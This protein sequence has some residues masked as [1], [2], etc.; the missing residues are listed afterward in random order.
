LSNRS[1]VLVNADEH[2]NSGWELTCK[3]QADFDFE[4]YAWSGEGIL[5]HLQRFLD[6]FDPDVISIT[7]YRLGP[8]VQPHESE[9]NE[10]DCWHEEHEDRQGIMLKWALKDGTGYKFV[11]PQRLFDEISALI[12]SGVTKLRS[13]KYHG[14]DPDGKM[15]KLF[16]DPP[17][18][19]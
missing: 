7:Y 4:A 18:A 19:K 5:T 14:A 10:L 12:R 8:F 13:N 15:R 9:K 1:A 6:R 17:E 3:T 2:E 16:R 11:E